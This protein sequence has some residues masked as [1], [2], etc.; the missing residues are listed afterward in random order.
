MKRLLLLCLLVFSFPVLSPAQ[1]AENLYYKVRNKL[2]SVKDYIA[3]VRIKLDVTFMKVPPL[4]GKLYFKSP[5]KM[6]LERNG[7]ISILPKNSYNLT[8]NNLLPPGKVTVID[9]GYDTFMQ[10]RVHLIKVIPSNDT[11]DIV[12]TKISIDEANLLVLHTETTTRD[13]GTINM[14]LQFGRYSSY[15]L[16]DRVTFFINLKDYKL[17]KGVTMDYTAA[18]DDMMKKAKQAKVKKG[19]VQIDY[20]DY[21]MNTGL[22]DDFFKEK[23]Q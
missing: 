5:D 1:D 11:G 21:K 3:D 9:G 20:L 23:K 17:P 2:L 16:P 4:K 12:L 15:A 6:K 8:L 7:G 10:R 19:R 14:D 13:N 22:T 18:D